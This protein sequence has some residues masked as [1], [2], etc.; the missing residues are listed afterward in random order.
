MTGRAVLFNGNI[1]S[2]T[3][4]LASN[5]HQTELAEWKNVVAGSVLLHVFAHAL[6]KKLAI[7]CE[8]HVNEVYDNNT[9]HIAQTKLTS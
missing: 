5:L 1:H 4:A 8:V 6:I 3:Y 2:R 7:Y 9:S